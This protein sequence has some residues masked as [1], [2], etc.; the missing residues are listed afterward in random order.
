MPKG[1]NPG[2]SVMAPFFYVGRELAVFYEAIEHRSRTPYAYAADEKTLHLRLRTKRDDVA[3]VQLIYGDPYM[4]ANGAWQ[5]RKR[6][7]K[8]VAS[9]TWFDYWQAA[10]QPPYRRLRYGFEITDAAGARTVYT[11]RGF[12][13]E[14]PNHTN[15]YF[16]FPF[17][18]GVDVFAP[19]EWVKDTVWYQI[20]PERFANGDPA[21]DP[22]GVLPWGSAPPSPT[23]W[24]GG[25]L[26][27]IIDHLDY[28]EAL[29]V[30]GI[31]L[32]PIFQAS[33][34]HKYD[35][36]DYFRIDR[37]F[38]DA[39]TL[40]R[41]VAACHDRGIRVM[42]DAVFNHC[43]FAFP[44]FQ[45]VL[46]KGERSK[47]KDWF[48][49]RAFPVETDPPNYETFA[50]TPLMPKLNTENPEVQNYLLDVAAYWIRECDID[51]WR[52]DVANEVDH[53]FWRAFRRHVKAL[54]PDLY[55]LGEVWHDA[56][57]WLEGD[58]FDAV[59]N[60]RFTAAALDFIA[61]RKRDARAFQNEVVHLL[62]SYP[63][64]VTHVWFNLLG[65]HDT[66]RILTACGGRVAD[67]KLLF[68]L[69]MTFPGTPCI[70]YGDEIGME[71]G[72]DPGCRACMK[73]AESEQN[74][75]LKETVQR[76]IRLRKTHDVLR[77][78]GELSFIES[79]CPD[80]AA[81]GRTSEACAALVFINR[82]GEAAEVALPEWARG[83]RAVDLWTDTSFTAG[84]T[85]R[86]PGGSFKILKWDL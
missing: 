35:T 77:N 38:G 68:A 69:L 60:Y 70:Y 20:F 75:E 36:M 18:H 56:M 23:N 47:F 41:L 39:E 55:I 43:G 5:Y 57:P 26:Q 32:T 42:L 7:M 71:G 9:D 21:N 85:C 74:P 30:N 25:D 27:G 65:S 16:C 34:N 37:H 61:S 40:R 72:N 53:A 79:G 12:F 84:E 54:K 19:P 6:M 48:H 82:G 62:Y 8:K 64:T 13:A 50:F 22:E 59:M 28:L 45:D 49:L 4:W 58:Q 80:V 33:S 29:G 63:Q 66:E 67:V 73:W 1:N 44:P 76:L 51:G 83:K 17:L 81:F 52:L 2:A 15:D 10:V 86:V 11:E 31:Y 24:F 14:A 46:K 78:G 3:A